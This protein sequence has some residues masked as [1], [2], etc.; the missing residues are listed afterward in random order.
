VRKKR[1]TTNSE[2]ITITHDASDAGHGTQ[3]GGHDET[4]PSQRSQQEHTPRTPNL[5]DAPNVEK[6]PYQLQELSAPR[7]AAA[8]SE[9]GQLPQD[10]GTGSSTYI[11]RSHYTGDA[12]VDEAAARAYTLSR[13]TGPS[14]LERKTLELWN[15]YALPPRAVHESL[16]EAF[17]EYCHPWMPVMESNDVLSRSASDSSL[18]LSQA[19][20]LAASRVATSASIQAFS[21]SADI[22]QRAKALYWVGYEKTPLTVIKAITMLHWYTPDGPAHVSYDTSEYWLKIG[23]G[24]AYQIGLHREPSAGPERAIRRRMWWTLVVGAFFM[25]RP[26]VFTLNSL[27]AISHVERTAL[28]FRPNTD[29][30]QVRDS[31][32]SVSRGR[33]RAIQLEDADVSP[34]TMEDF[35]ESPANGELFIAYVEICRAVGDLVQA[36]SRKKFTTDERSKMDATLFR[37]TRILPLHLRLADFSVTTQAYELRPHDFRARQLHVPYLACVII[38]S[39]SRSPHT[40]VS[41]AAIFAASFLAGIY[42]DFLARNLV[43]RLSPT[44]TTFGF[45][46]GLLLISLRP[47]PTLW[48]AAQSDLVTIQTVLQELSSRWRSAIGASK[49]I[50]KALQSEVP[51]NILPDMVLPPLSRDEAPLFEGF[52]L[53]LCRMWQA[54]ETER[55]SQALQIG[56][57][58]TFTRHAD[59]M[60]GVLTGFHGQ[61]GTD[62]SMGLDFG[63]GEALFGGAS[64]EGMPDYFWGDWGLN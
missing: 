3:T 11:G 47:Y 60:A 45:M 26:S 28:L 36:Y 58:P 38:M 50:Q 6:S 61:Q 56:L 14:D 35:A 5:T 9:T 19:V 7:P 43:A 42:E 13:H 64:F 52:P 59:P 4:S 37:W 55:A 27:P 16:V 34:P 29:T 48:A 21:S 25:S 41:P 17:N 10:P 63:D 23:V 32:I 51:T 8:G 53:E 12:P 40:A 22:Y 46:A 18:L 62:P 15:V 31:L 33:P 49:V 1:K 54:Y 2:N 30:Q 20:Y 44:F 39:R 57:E 24:L